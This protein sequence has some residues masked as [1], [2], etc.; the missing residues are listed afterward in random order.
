MD[1][2]SPL[3]LYEDNKGI[4]GF[5]LRRLLH[6]Q[7]GGHERVRQVVKTVYK[8][9]QSGMIKAHIDSTYALEDVSSERQGVWNKAGDG[10]H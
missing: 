3:R 4:I 8:L 6:Q 10:K 7:P 9:W 1:K 5:N 2:V